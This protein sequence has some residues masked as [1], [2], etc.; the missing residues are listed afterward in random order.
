MGTEDVSREEA[1]KAR[2]E[3]NRQQ[4]E[5]RLKL[6]Q[7]QQKLRLRGRRQI[8]AGFGVW[9]IAVGIFAYTYYR[10]PD[11]IKGETENLKSIIMGGPS[12][13]PNS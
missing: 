3:I 2:A 6:E 8:R 1:K 7:W 13:G 12:S 9:A 11:I 5:N 10:K 4:I